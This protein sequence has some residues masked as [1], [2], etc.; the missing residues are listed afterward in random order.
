[1]FAKLL[2][3]LLVAAVLACP[4]RCRQEAP[5][6]AAH[7]EP[8][9]CCERCASHQSEAS[10]ELVPQPG[11]QPCDDCQCI[12]SGAISK[13]SSQY[14]LLLQ[15]A[16]SADWHPGSCEAVPVIALGLFGCWA[17]DPFPDDRTA[18]SGRETRC[19]LMSF[20]C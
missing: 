1:M 5:V 6:C 12:R 17:P 15:F 10:H 4:Y 9:A 7:A 2:S 19:R 8:P 16:F 11:E 20:L 14:E 13:D 3:T 18:D